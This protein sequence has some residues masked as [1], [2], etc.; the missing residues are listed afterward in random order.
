MPTQRSKPRNEK[1]ADLPIELKQNMGTNRSYWP[2]WPDHGVIHAV[3]WSSKKKNPHK[4]GPWWRQ[5]PRGPLLHIGRISVPL[6]EAEKPLKL[7][8]KKK[9]K[10][11][12]SQI[13]ALAQKKSLGDQHGIWIRRCCASPWHP[14]HASCIQK[15]ANQTFMIW[16]RAGRR[17]SKCCILLFVWYKLP[18]CD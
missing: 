12:K 11:G 14:K 10:L 7:S 13:M 1:S 8:S 4:N 9:Q 6:A 2:F 16:D 15:E 3:C 17:L 5:M 18:S